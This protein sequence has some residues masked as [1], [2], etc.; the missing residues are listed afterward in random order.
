MTSHTGLGSW[1]GTFIGVIGGPFF[2]FF[3]ADTKSTYNKHLILLS[4]QK[5]VKLLQQLHSIM[6]VLYK[7]TEYTDLLHQQVISRRAVLN[8]EQ[9][10]LYRDSRKML[11]TDVGELM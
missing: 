1:T 8:S 4:T 2:R 10:I 11:G 9:C 5:L 3:S 6:S 7:C